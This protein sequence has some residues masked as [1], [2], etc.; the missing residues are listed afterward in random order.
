M[1]TPTMSTPAT[2]PNAW[3]RAFR[4]RKEHPCADCRKPIEAMDYCV[5][6]HEYG[7]K[8]WLHASCAEAREQKAGKGAS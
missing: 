2:K 5:T 8:R 4:A 7:E 3:A 6:V 1:P